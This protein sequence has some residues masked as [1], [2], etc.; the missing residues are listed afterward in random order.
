LLND[1]YNYN[2]SQEDQ[3]KVISQL[4]GNM[5]LNFIHTV[6]GFKLQEIMGLQNDFSLN[7]YK[8]QL[9]KGILYLNGAQKSE[10]LLVYNPQNPINWQSFYNIIDNS[11]VYQLQAM[12]GKL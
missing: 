9:L 7:P 6:V 5:D 1:R 8:P 12:V 2:W 4:D 10:E 11:D 3:S